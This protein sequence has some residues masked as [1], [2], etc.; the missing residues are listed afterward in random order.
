MKDSQGSIIYVGK[1]KNLKSR[2]QS[3]FYHSKAHSRKV[4]KLVKT[5]RDFD[6]IETD[7]EF[8]AFMLE[9]RLIKEIKPYFN[10]LMKNPL[11]YAYIVI[12]LDE[13]IPQMEVSH[14]IHK[15]NGYQYFGP[16]TSKSTAEKAIE[17]FKDCYKINC[18][19]HTLKTSPCLN[20]TIGLCIGMCQGGAALAQ[21]RSIIDKFISLLNGSDMSLLEE[22]NEKM[23]TAAEHFDF[24]TA[25]KFRN[26]IKYMETLIHKE[27]MIEFTE[28]NHNIVMLEPIGEACFKIFY[29]KR[30]EILFSEIYSDKD[31]NRESAAA[32]VSAN[33]M[34]YFAL[35]Y[36]AAELTRDEIDEAQ[37][38]YHYL[39]SSHCRYRIIPETWLESKSKVKQQVSEWFSQV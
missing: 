31:V 28:K 30:N 11:S 8:E 6:Y 24:E 22:M 3:Y 16:F 25:A 21:Y 29:M 27:R 20:F 4:E 14:S 19:R 33:I 9:C 39:K 13:E 34:K 23:L 17:G 26:S 7:T 5:L 15:G 37:I 2:V 36:S 10:K 35:P 32:T 38:I 1:S 18:T 12:K